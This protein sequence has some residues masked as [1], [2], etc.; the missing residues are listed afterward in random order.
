MS[1]PDGTDEEV[2]EGERC[3]LVYVSAP[4]PKCGAN[5][6]DEAGNIC[7]PSS[8][9]T[10]ER[11]CPGEFKNGVSVQPTPES[12]ADM[13]RWIDEQVARDEEDERKRDARRVNR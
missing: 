1:N 5:T 11:S 3:G 13:N 7:K 9:E 10:G 4:C 6:E 8:D 2:L 12:I